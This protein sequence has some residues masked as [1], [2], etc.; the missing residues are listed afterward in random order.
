MTA[1]A[2]R[3]PTRVVVPP[4]GVSTRT[5]LRVTAA[6]LAV[7]AAM[8]E[9][10][11]T[12]RNADLR[13]AAAQV[14]RAERRKRLGYAAHTRL[15][16]T[17]TADTNALV[18]LRRRNLVAERAHL[19]AAVAVL[20][21]RLAAPTNDACN[22]A[23]LRGARPSRARP[24][25]TCKDGY[26]T[27]NERHQKTRRRQLLAARLA[28]VEARLADGRLPLLPGGRRRLGARLHLADAGVTEQQWRD[29]WATARAWC[30]AAGST[31]EHGGNRVFKLDPATGTLAVTVPL[32]VAARHGLTAPRAKAAGAVLTLAAAVS[33]AHH[34]AELRARLA[35]RLGVR[36]DLEPVYAGGGAVKMYLRALWTREDVPPTPTLASAR[37]G[38]VLGAT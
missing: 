24:C 33:F 18:A 19:R 20:D 25:P 15:L 3:S 12:L 32:P 16:D 14:G 2:L 37:A 21:R 31:G 34:G 29:D 10:T 28:Q 22:H 23:P 27:R 7:L 1:L 17:M 4:V 5:R 13:L 9:H 36:F 38:G 35:N 11:T 8:V 26:P 6:E 30:G